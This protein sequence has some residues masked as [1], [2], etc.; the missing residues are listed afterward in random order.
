MADQSRNIG[1]V[2]DDEDVGFHA[3]IV[4]VPAQK[5]LIFNRTVT[6]DVEFRSSVEEKRRISRRALTQ[7]RNFFFD[8]LHSS[9]TLRSPDSSI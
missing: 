6:N 9:W 5:P 1:I 4:A 8:D 7:F 3:C 2:F